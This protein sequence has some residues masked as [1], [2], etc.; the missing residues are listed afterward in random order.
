MIREEMAAEIALRTD[1]PLE[2]VE[3]VLDEEDIMFLE[4]ET[5]RKKTTAICVIGGVIVVTVAAVAVIYYLD[6][7]EKINVRQTVDTCK[8]R[9]SEKCQKPLAS[10]KDKF[11]G[12]C[13]C[14]PCACKA[15]M[16]AFKTFIL[17]KIISC[18]GK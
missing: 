18:C 15:H 16:D 13:P 9:I 12:K 1:L 3:E 7:K 6:K 2:E 5:R 11:S 10:V 4:E 14:S 17:D 8:D